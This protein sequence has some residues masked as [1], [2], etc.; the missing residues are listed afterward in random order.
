MPSISAMEDKERILASR[1]WAQPGPVKIRLV[2]VLITFCAM[3]PVLRLRD[4]LSPT[5]ID[6][7]KV[8]RCI[9][10]M[11]PT[12]PPLDLTTHLTHALLDGIVNQMT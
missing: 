2:V 3:C 4:V 7:D 11:L 8:G 5:K 9:R 10:S 6:F 12:P 1:F